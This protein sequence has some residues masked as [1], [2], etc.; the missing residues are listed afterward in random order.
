MPEN[1]S[2][3]DRIEHCKRAQQQGF[4]ASS[5]TDDCNAV[6]TAHLKAH[7]LQQGAASDAALQMASH[8][9]WSSV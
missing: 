1:A 9:Q 4:A 7:V 2:G 3:I 5:R 8:K 6:P